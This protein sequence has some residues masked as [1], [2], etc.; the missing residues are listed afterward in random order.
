MHN[1]TKTNTELPQTIGRTLNNKLTTPTETF[2]QQGI[3]EKYL[4]LFRL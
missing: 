2:L 1:I 4:M 3:S